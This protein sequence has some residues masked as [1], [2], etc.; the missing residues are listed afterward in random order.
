M[1]NT[2]MKMHLS[3]IFPAA[4]TGITA[5]GLAGFIAVTLSG[6]SDANSKAQDAAAPAAPSIPVAVVAAED[7]IETQEFSG[8]LE[9]VEHVEIRARVAGFIDSVSFQA[10]T[11]VKKGDILFRIDPRPY[12][13][14]LTRVEAAAASASAKAELAKLELNRAEKLLA[15]KAI[16]QREFD[17]KSS[18]LKELAA[19]ARAAQAAY[20]GAKLNLEYTQVRAPIDGRVGKAEITVGNLVDNSAVLTSLVSNNRIYAEFDGDEETYIRVGGQSQRGAPVSVKVG[21]AR[22][23]GFPH[24][25]KLEFVDNQLNQQTG[26]IRMR[27]VLDNADNKLAPGL[28]AR[29]SIDTGNGSDKRTRALLIDERAVG[30]DQSHK[31]VYVVSAGSK[32]EY[33]EVTL[34][35]TTANGMRVVRTGLNAGDRIVVNGLQRVKPGA[36][37][38]PQMVPMN[39]STATVATKPELSANGKAAS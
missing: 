12:Q 34:G 39:P 27:A 20:E 25:G 4:L 26:S 16:P 3:R 32:V 5:V 28:F 15:D 23:T 18:G 36:L 1:K 35:P 14:E 37:I 30:N 7:L 38:A 17:E 31:F 33:R 29:V 2:L 13:A 9:A 22:E 8:R 6:C 19:N 21:L 11:Q 10:G 24:V